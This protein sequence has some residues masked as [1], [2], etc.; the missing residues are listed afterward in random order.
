MHQST[1]AITRAKG[2]PS[3]ASTMFLQHPGFTA[4]SI[5][6]TTESS[7]S[8][9]FAQPTTKSP[10]TQQQQTCHCD[11]EAERQRHLRQNQDI[12][13]LITLKSI[14]NRRYEAEISQL[15]RTNLS[16][17][18]ALAKAQKQ[19]LK[20]T[21]VDAIDNLYSPSTTTLRKEWAQLGQ[22]QQQIPYLK[23]R[24]EK[25][26][27]SLHGRQGWKSAEYDAMLSL[28][29]R[30]KKQKL[31]SLVSNTIPDNLTI[32]K[33]DYIRA[34][35]EY[36]QQILIENLRS[37]RSTIEMYKETLKALSK[38]YD[39]PK[40]SSVEDNKG[41]YLDQLVLR[42]G[43]E[44]GSTQNIFNRSSKSLAYLSEASLLS[45]K[46]T[47]LSSSMQT[48][49]LSK[50]EQT[51]MQQI[52]SP[53]A[54]FDTD[55]VPG[56]ICVDNTNQAFGYYQSS[57]AGISNARSMQLFTAPLFNTN[58]I[59]QNAGESEISYES[60]RRVTSDSAEQTS[61]ALHGP[62]RQ[63]GR[64]VPRINANI[65]PT[66][67]KKDSNDLCN[68][69]AVSILKPSHQSPLSRTP[70]A[71]YSRS[72]NFQELIVG[73]QKRQSITTASMTPKERGGTNPYRRH[74]PLSYIRTSPSLEAKRPWYPQEHPIVK[75]QSKS[76]PKFNNRDTAVK[77]CTPVKLSK[78]EEGYSTID[79]N[80]SSQG[81]PLEFS[82]KKSFIDLT[83][84]SP[85]SNMPT[86]VTRKKDVS[87]TPSRIPRSR[88]R[89]R[90]FNSSNG[91]RST[92]SSESLKSL[93]ADQLLRR[94]NKS[95]LG[96][97][98]V[99]I[100]SK[101][102]VQKGLSS[103]IQPIS[104]KSII[105]TPANSTKVLSTPSKNQVE[106]AIVPVSTQEHPSPILTPAV[107]TEEEVN[108]IS[109]N[110]TLPLEHA[111]TM[112]TKTKAIASK[113][114]IQLTPFAKTQRVTRSVF[115][116]KFRRVTRSITAAASQML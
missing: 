78:C 64:I 57:T 63:L 61:A 73:N 72:I 52:A 53:Q 82:T 5:E 68:G 110:D 94:M 111:P 65:L 105:R 20:D 85:L 13:R 74:V 100:L 66:L 17:A 46:S 102:I 25:V 19:S 10:I 47:L 75:T 69:R 80:P 29:P 62:P 6:N 36:E 92:L 4:S 45:T 115:S 38:S 56:I 22:I 76:P 51:P 12:I 107:T 71:A 3:F 40:K 109:Y 55:A 96:T 2:H 93:S 1:S 42:K 27:P 9:I 11:F 26:L 23:Q 33:L 95:L 70:L 77:G 103:S 32:L 108:A 114:S 106:L 87:Y 44:R 59:E 39:F 35:Y 28:T 113:Q 37:H 50:A 81:K 15:E 84:T 60:N 97:S 90:S 91:R 16:L 7:L 43:Y 83:S 14:Q 112:I 31:E 41:G 49:M 99:P 24:V 18:V 48:I 8:H 104:W 116:E 88:H 86:T 34:I 21:S 30:S 98:K 89:V 79:S 54:F 58:L 67:S 101:T